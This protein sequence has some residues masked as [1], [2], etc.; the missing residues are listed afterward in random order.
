MDILQFY[1][2]IM[3]IISSGVYISDPTITRANR[4]LSAIWFLG[5]DMIWG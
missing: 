4:E 5:T 3:V 1:I 2:V